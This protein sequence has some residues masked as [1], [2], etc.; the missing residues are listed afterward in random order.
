MQP[1]HS[2]SRQY[3]GTQG[4]GLG[5]GEYTGGI[6]GKNEYGREIQ[7]LREEKINNREYVHYAKGGIGGIWNTY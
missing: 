7:G 4:R 6:G 2:Y 3:R 1:A 5:A